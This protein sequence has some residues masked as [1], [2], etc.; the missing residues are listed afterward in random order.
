MA[1]GWTPS[2]VP[3]PWRKKSIDSFTEPPST[4]RRTHVKS[5][6]LYSKGFRSRGYET[7]YADTIIELEL[8]DMVD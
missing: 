3:Y 7:A 1:R 6:V 8:Y 4:I 5:L 2:V